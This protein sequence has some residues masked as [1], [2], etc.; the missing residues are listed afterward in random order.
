MKTQSIQNRIKNL[1]V[2]GILTAGTLLAGTGCDLDNPASKSVLNAASSINE[3][4][5][6]PLNPV[7][8]GSPSF[9]FD[10]T[11]PNNGLSTPREES[12]GQ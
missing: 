5:L 3:P 1:T 12:S 2:A 11:A 9:S 8:V 4:T 10:P 7:V 6:R